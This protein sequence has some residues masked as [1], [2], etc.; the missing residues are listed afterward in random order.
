MFFSFAANLGQLVHMSRMDHKR[1]VKVRSG[2]SQ[3]KRP[4]K[5]CCT[6]CSAT[7][8][9]VQEQTM[10]TGRAE[11]HMEKRKRNGGLVRFGIWGMGSTKLRD[12]HPPLVGQMS[13]L[14]LL[15]KK[16]STGC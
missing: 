13:F 9:G 6:S 1:Q 15:D 7:V 12:V 3:G 2:L 10:A 14:I 11:T 4:V 16:L 5:C 8:P